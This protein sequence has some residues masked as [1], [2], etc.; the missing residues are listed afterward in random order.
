MHGRRQ[1]NKVGAELLV[2][3]SVRVR[4][5]TRTRGSGNPT[6][7]NQSFPT[8]H[9]SFPSCSIILLHQTHTLFFV[10]QSAH[11]LICILLLVRY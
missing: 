1:G 7:A 8:F 11:Y 6:N 9:C 2:E 3:W 10:F 4:T 5:L